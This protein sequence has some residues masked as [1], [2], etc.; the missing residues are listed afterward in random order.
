VTLLR[1]LFGP[2]EARANLSSPQVPISSATILDFIGAAPA[3]GAGVRVTEENSV[4]MPAIWRAVNVISGTCAALPLH[5]YRSK[6][7]TDV[8][9][10]INWQLLDQVHPDLT[11]FE[12]FELVYTHL[13]LWGN[14]YLQKLRDQN[15]RV[16]ELWV[17]HPSRVKAGRA[18]DLS[19]VYQ[20]DGRFED[21]LTDREIL[22]IP[23]F[24]YD[25]VVGVSP[26]RAARNAVGLGMAAEEF[27][28]RFFDNGSLAGGILQTEQR[29]DKGQADALKSRWRRKAQGL[30]NAHDVVVLDSGA[31]F[32]Q[33]TIPPDD[34][35]FIET[36]KFQIDEVARLFGIPAHMLMEVDRTTSWGTGIEQQTLGFVRFNLQTWLVRVEQRLSTLLPR[37]QY[38]RYVVDGLLRSDTAGR[39]AAYAT[40]LQWGILNRNEVRALEE[41]APV[42]GGDA[43]MVPL[44]MADPNGA[45]A[46]ASAPAPDAITTGGTADAATVNA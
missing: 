46:P 26:I 42:D 33:L 45:A 21:P 30:E 3:A 6:P 1:S 24:G 27:G 5:A 39:Y 20:V 32:Q 14:A 43:F 35:Q 23:G 31:K 2:S 19:K 36:R 41:R 11:N 34:A 29:L 25:G 12:L 37:P 15:G 40:A 13:A 22:H 16:A 10:P 9:E 18:S 44:N 8:A 38:V 4:G 7:G 17:I 28:S